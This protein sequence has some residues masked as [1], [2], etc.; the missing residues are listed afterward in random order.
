M[1]PEDILNTLKSAGYELFHLFDVDELKDKY[2]LSKIDNPKVFC[3]F[4]FSH[5]AAY[6]DNEYREILI[7]AIKEAINELDGYLKGEEK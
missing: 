1:I 4:E 3:R 7:E 5:S 6:N 2:M